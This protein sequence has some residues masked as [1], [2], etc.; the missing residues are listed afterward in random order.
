MP[1]RASVMVAVLTVFAC[2]FTVE[3]AQ[4]SATQFKRKWAQNVAVVLADAV[5]SPPL[6]DRTSSL[7]EMASNSCGSRRRSIECRHSRSAV[8]NG[9]DT[10]PLRPSLGHRDA[11]HLSPLQ[12][13]A[14]R[15][16]AWGASHG[17][18]ASRT[19]SLSHS[20]AADWDLTSRTD[21]VKADAR[22]A[23]LSML[24]DIQ[25]GHVSLRRQL[26]RSQSDSVVT[27]ASISASR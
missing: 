4:R 19:M 21:P 25:S 1:L 17:G 22:K 11:A 12:A 5:P 27:V 20:T 8:I 23:L 13:G 14:R 7:L 6:S 16:S 24:S 15:R 10:T 26:R 9:R 2:E 3:F 18:E